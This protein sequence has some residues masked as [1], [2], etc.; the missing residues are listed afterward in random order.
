MTIVNCHY[1]IKHWPMRVNYRQVI[2]SQKAV[3]YRIILYN[4]EALQKPINLTG[5]KKGNV[6]NRI[7]S[8]S[9]NFLLKC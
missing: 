2:F 9:I 1:E 8:F 6:S 5:E 3:K 4:K 7:D